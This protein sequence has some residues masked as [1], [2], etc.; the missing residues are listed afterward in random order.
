MN[1]IFNYGMNS[2]LHKKTEKTLDIR[3]HAINAQRPYSLKKKIHPVHNKNTALRISTNA[4][5]PTLCLTMLW[6]KKG[7]LAQNFGPI[8]Y[9]FPYCF[10]PQKISYKLTQHDNPLSYNSLLK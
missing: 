7:L 9:D 3:L 5:D 1:G 2:N 4:E 10:L 6:M 8:K